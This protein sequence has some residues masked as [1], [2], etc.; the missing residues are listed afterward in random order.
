MHFLQ[1]IYFSEVVHSEYEN[2]PMFKK[3][4]VKNAT[5]MLQDTYDN[6]R[7]DRSD[8]FHT[9]VDY[10]DYTI[11]TNRITLVY[12]P[13]HILSK[14][15]Y[16]WYTLCQL[17]ENAKKS[18]YIQTPYAVL[19]DVMY[20]NLAS[21]G[22]DIDQ[23]SILLNSIAVGDNIYASADYILNKDKINDTGV[24]VY[25]FHGDYSMHNNSV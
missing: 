17:M 4:K 11:A 5:V 13:T 7:R 18:V 19:N 16:V 25:E 20:E 24:T 15:P 22:K 3:D 21:V 9:D 2:A 12:N 10:Y 23:F 8:I 14:E 6:L 1:T